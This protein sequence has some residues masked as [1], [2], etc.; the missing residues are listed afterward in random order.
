[1]DHE[2]ILEDRIIF[3]END[4]TKCCL[5]LMCFSVIAA[6]AALAQ[7]EEALW[8]A[9][10]GASSEAAL[11][12][13]QSKREALGG[14]IEVPDVHDNVADQDSASVVITAEGT[15]V[16]PDPLSPNNKLPT[17][18]MVR[19]AVLLELHGMR[20][21]AVDLCLQ[22]PAKYRTH[23]PQCADIFKR[24]IRLQTFAKDRK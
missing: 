3:Q 16:V 9:D 14:A 21:S 6:N 2:I 11:K 8:S 18:L 20:K 24:E 4:V 10:E 12:V 23:L 5:V 7:Q 1:L 17:T 13:M 19:T 15:E 22:L